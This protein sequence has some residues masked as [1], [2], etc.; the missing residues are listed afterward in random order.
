MG[1]LTACSL[2]CPD[3]CSLE[4]TVEDG[5]MI[6]IGA[7]ADGP[8]PA[9]NGW[10][11]AKVKQTPQLLHGPDR[12]TSPLRRV[13]A[14]GS[15]EFV[16]I[17]WDEALD[18]VADTVRKAA[19]T[20]GWQSVVPYLY[21]SSAGNLGRSGLSPLVWEHLGAARTDITI[22]AATVGEA[23]DRTYGS[24]ASADPEDLRHSDLIVVW[25]ANPNVSNPHLSPVIEERRRA[26]AKLVVVD[27]RR[28]PIADRADL[29]LAVLPGTDGVLAMAVSA[30]IDRNGHIDRA[31]IER[32]VDGADQYLEACREWTVDRAAQICGVDGA[33]IEQFAEMYGTIRPAMLRVG[34]GQERNRNGG[35]ASRAVFALPALAGQ[36]GV[37]GSGVFNSIDGG[38][39]YDA[40]ALRRGVVGDAPVPDRR[41]INMNRLGRILRDDEGGHVAVLFVQGSN[42][43]A[44]CPGQAIVLEGLQ[45]ED[46]LTVVHDLTMTDTALYADVVLPATSQFEVEEVVGSYGSFV[47]QEAPAVIPRVGQSRTNDEVSVGIGVR[48]GLDPV[49]WDPSPQRVRHLA[50]G[51]RVLPFMKRPTGLTVQFRDVFPQDRVHLVCDQEG[52]DPLPA[53][54]ALDTPELPLTLITPATSRTTSSMFGNI[55]PAAADV[56]LHPDDAAARRLASG[57]RARITD[58][59]HT[60]EATVAIDATLRPGLATMPKGMWRRDGHNGFTANVFAP[61]HLSDLAGGASFNDARV[62]VSAVASLSD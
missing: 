1:L 20:D 50:L 39:G 3:S 60:I 49:Q 42:P 12:L 29:H 45:R 54:R 8:N 22:C 13:G 26:G 36:F 25:G 31:F 15:G 6:S 5:R 7:A 18:L 35:S 34:W 14:K 32:H 57:D 16:E 61:D 51:D 37:P 62:E 21:S 33:D 43:A 58:G 38:T 23:W 41:A 30:L 24:M 9:T 47:V 4:V 46:L 28:T 2:D 10:I 55:A 44:T 59:R 52:V 27:P 17:T 56:H 48:L 19:D 11:C 40:S 53:F